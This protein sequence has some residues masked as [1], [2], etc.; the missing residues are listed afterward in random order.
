MNQLIAPVAEAAI[1]PEVLIANFEKLVASTE[2]NR[3]SALW[4]AWHYLQLYAYWG[5]RL[6]SSDAE[7]KM[8]LDIKQPESYLFYGTM[9]EGYSQVHKACFSFLS[10]LFPR[11]VNLGSS[12]KRF[13]DDASKE[14][15]GLFSAVIELIEK[16]DGFSALDLLRDLRSTAT[17]NADEAAAVRNGLAS[18]RTQLAA[19]NSKVKNADEQV[20]KDSKTNQAVLD[21]YNGGEDA[22]GSIKQLSKQLQNEREEYKQDVIIASTTVTYAWI[23]LWGQ[24]SAII[25]AG[26]YGDKAA[27]MLRK[28]EED[29][30][31]LAKANAELSLAIQVRKVQD[32]AK[33]SL[34]KVAA[35]TELAIAYTVTVENSWRG[36]ES[37]IDLI[38]EKVSYM[39]KQRDGEEVLAAESVIKLYARNAEAA[40][41]R[42]VPP[43]ED[44]LAE[45]YIKISDQKS[46]LTD[47]AKQVEQALEVK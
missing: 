39:L 47:L 37:E 24:L 7:L 42:L 9:L 13:A 41:T 38:A 1:Q 44:L 16:K 29:E 12:L 18:F 45:P 4:Y 8:S 23:P 25:I 3:K 14:G 31:R 34:D 30:A 2:K 15:G 19:A 40:W 27:K 6:P 17:K 20:E 35:N 5:V 21:K 43:L 10:D 32:T 26:I 33:H 28:I 36:I 22:I 46:T 11:V